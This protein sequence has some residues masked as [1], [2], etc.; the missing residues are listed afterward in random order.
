MGWLS[1]TSHTDMSSKWINEPNAYDE[2][3]GTNTN[4]SSLGGGNALW[5][6]ISPTITSNRI[7]VYVYEQKGGTQY[8]PDIG[9]RIAH[10]GGTSG[11]WIGQVARNTWIEKTHTQY[12]GVISYR[13][14]FNSKQAGGSSLYL[15]EVDFWEVEAPPP[16]YISE[17][18]MIT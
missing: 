13:I 16:S 14:W 3:T 12:D 17:L 10:D 7:R 15:C 2:N 4:C 1:P 9:I 11:V 6:E 8:D 18:M 5:L